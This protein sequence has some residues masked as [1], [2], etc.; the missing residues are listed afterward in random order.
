VN[1]IILTKFDHMQYAAWKVWTYKAA[2][3]ENRCQLV[4]RK[5][6]SIVG[7]S[8]LVFGRSLLTAE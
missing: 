8:S 4:F 2:C 6:L 7:Q 5:P 1:R 3:L